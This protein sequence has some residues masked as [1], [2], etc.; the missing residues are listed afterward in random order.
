MYGTVEGDRQY[1]NRDLGSPSCCCDDLVRVALPLCSLTSSST[2]CC[3]CMLLSSE[4]TERGYDRHPSMDW[5][6]GAATTVTPAC[7]NLWAR[8]AVFERR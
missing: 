3:R 7:M 8:A 2:E 1:S 6:L 5:T 4:V